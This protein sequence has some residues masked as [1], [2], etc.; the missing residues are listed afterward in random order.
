M[1]HF[2][3][4]TINL[5]N[6]KVYIGIHSTDNINDGYLGSGYALR[7]AIALYGR[8][9]FTREILS[10]H[11]TRLQAFETEKRIVNEQ[12]INSTNN[13]NITTGG[14]GR[15]GPNS[16][17][18][19]VSIYDNNLNLLR[20]VDTKVEAAKL[21]N[22]NPVYIT[23]AC[24]NAAQG[25]ACK[26]LDYYVCHQEDK[27]KKK[28]TSYLLEHNRRLSKRNKGRK[29]PKHSDFMR[30][31]M[32][33][34]RINNPVNNIV[35]EWKHN[36]GKTFVGTRLDLI[37]KHPTH[38]INNSELGVLIKGGYRSHRGWSII[39]CLEQLQ[40]RKRGL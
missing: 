10:F 12:W 17:S 40:K 7:H 21:I 32:K 38:K 28:D 33:E 6:N 16:R 30:R 23:N 1:Y 14:Q 34:Q 25:K 5:I 36:T 26:V 3:Y 20:V 39:K 2:V 18:K 4:K 13:Y 9:N 22:T 8:E 35:Y 15:R 27:P 19:P 11:E 29:R 24:K 31:R 37:E